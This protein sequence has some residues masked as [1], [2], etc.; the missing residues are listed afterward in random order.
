[1]WIGSSEVDALLD[2][3]ASISL[4]SLSLANKFRFS[5]NK[6]VS[7]NIVS[8]FGS[9]TSVLGEAT[10]NV[11]I[12]PRTYL[13][14]ALVL[15]ESVYPIL[16]GL[17]W[18]VTNRCKLN[19]DELRLE[20][21]SGLWDP[22]TV[23]KEKYRVMPVR[24]KLRVTLEM[25]ERALIPIVIPDLYKVDEIDGVING[26]NTEQPWK[27]ARTLSKITNGMAFAEVTN[28]G[29]GPWTIERNR[30]LGWFEFKPSVA[31]AIQIALAVEMEDVPSNEKDEAKISRGTTSSRPT[32]TTSIKNACNGLCHVLH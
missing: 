20:F 24:S 23:K 16:L 21:P 18:L 29:G 19:F 25:G 11:R 14:N 22:I 9:S 13:C 26:L 2:S 3:C 10:F 6:N 31:N 32:R 15:K 8:I 1:M 4:I 17:D 28:M 7:T 30:Q 12:G 5:I 27:I